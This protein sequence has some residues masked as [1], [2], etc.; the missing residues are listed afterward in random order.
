M[1]LS[2]GPLRR[3]ALAFAVALAAAGPAASDGSLR[4]DWTA[5]TAGE[6]ALLRLGLALGG[7]RS[8]LEVEQEGRDNAAE[9]RR[10]GRGHRAWL[11]QSG[12]GHSASLTQRGARQTQAILQYGRDTSADVVQTGRG[13]AG[14][15]LLWG[16]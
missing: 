6:A 13:R 2:A 5:R 15:T 3:L 9:V 10:S 4:L 12:E 11:R 14:V 7:L 1:G 8:G 16:F